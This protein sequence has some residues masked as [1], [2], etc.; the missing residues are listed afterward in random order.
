V[1]VKVHLV[2]IPKHPQNLI[3]RMM[4]VGKLDRYMFKIFDN[5]FKRVNH[6]LNAEFSSFKPIRG[7]KALGNQGGYSEIVRIDGVSVN[8]PISHLNYLEERLKDRMPVRFTYNNFDEH[9][10]IKNL[11]LVHSHFVPNG[12]YKVQTYNLTMEVLYGEII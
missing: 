4:I 9:I 6:S 10:V 12:D 2:T 1:Q 3:G 11:E 5:A 7:Q 8:L